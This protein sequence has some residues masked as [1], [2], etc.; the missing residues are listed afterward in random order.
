VISDDHRRG[1]HVLDCRVLEGE[2]HLDHSSQLHMELPPGVAWT[3]PDLSAT[4]RDLIAG[5]EGES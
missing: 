3:Q 5:A 1:G 2:V 4:K